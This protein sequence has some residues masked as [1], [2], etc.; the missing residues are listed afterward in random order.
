[1]ATR[2]PELEAHK[3]AAASKKVNGDGDQGSGMRD[4]ALAC[5]SRQLL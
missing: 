1:V 3:R 2:L 4:Q 5:G